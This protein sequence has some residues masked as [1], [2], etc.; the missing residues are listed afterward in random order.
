MNVTVEKIVKETDTYPT[1]IVDEKAYEAMRSFVRNCDKE[2]GW[3]ALCTKKE[4]EYYIYETII[5]DQEVS[6]TTTDLH[7]KGLQSVAEN[8]IH[9]GRIGELDNVRC[10]GHSH[11][12][13][14][15]T[16]S[17][18]DNETFEEYYTQCEDYFI[19]IIMN[20]KNEYR[21]DLADYPSGL[22]YKNLELFVDYTEEESELRNQIAEL[23]NKLKNTTDKLETLRKE[24]SDAIDEEVKILIKNHVKE[25]K[26]KYTWKYPYED[27][28]YKFNY[29]NDIPTIKVYMGK[30][31]KRPITAILEFRD[32][33]NIVESSVFEI[34]RNFQN[35]IVNGY[36]VFSKYA[37]GDWSKL[38]EA[39]EEYV[40]DEYMKYE[41]TMEVS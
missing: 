26:T 30:E 6:G 36:K 33:E 22:I 40:L 39:A 4:N 8:L 35:H 5:C 20:K 16:P 3:L 7:E 34:R 41:D 19:R 37:T 27:S 15:V 23:E 9:T 31:V 24:K 11:V 21:A 2:I 29:K 38:Q 14:G 18:Q 32:M 28:G 12:N 1:I 17:F 10:W 13:M 25:E